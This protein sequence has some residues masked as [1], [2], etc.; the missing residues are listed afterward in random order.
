MRFV[1]KKIPKSL[2]FSHILFTSPGGKHVFGIPDRHF[3]RR[4]DKLGDY[5]KPTIL[6]RYLHELGTRSSTRSSQPG[7]HAERLSGPYRCHAF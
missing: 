6:R 5:N 4:Q 2:T 1:H 7:S 3:A